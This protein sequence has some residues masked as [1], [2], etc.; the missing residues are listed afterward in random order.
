MTDTSTTPPAAPGPSLA[1]AKGL[2]LGLGVL[3]IAGTA[4]LITLLVTRSP[5][6]SGFGEPSPI[7]L[8]E[9]E[10]ITDV[11]SSGDALVVLIDG[12]TGQRLLRVDGATGTQTAI[13]VEQR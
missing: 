5:E 2:A 9:G 1:V 6:S 4:L 3:L 13:A 12:P 10:R 7:V 8:G 11:A